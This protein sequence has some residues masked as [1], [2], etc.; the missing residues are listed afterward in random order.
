MPTSPAAV[1]DG[2][3]DI[4]GLAA[5]IEEMLAPE[6][7]RR[8]SEAAVRLAETRSLERHTDE[9]EALLREA[10]AWGARCGAT[11]RS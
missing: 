1:V 8:R 6:K 9:M 2:P 4:D 5:G 7:W 11:A 10:S 3:W